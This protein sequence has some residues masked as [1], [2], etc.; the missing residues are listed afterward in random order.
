MLAYDDKIRVIELARTSGIMAASSKYNLSRNRVKRY[1]NL[2]PGLKTGAG[3][4]KTMDPQMEA[5]LLVWIQDYS[6][7][8]HEFPKKELICGQA[9]MLTRVKG[10][11]ASKGWLEKFMRRNQL[12]LNSLRVNQNKPTKPKKVQ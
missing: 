8:Y 9:K 5:K 3:G 10:F 2:G 6:A 11:A 4:R 7:T 1:L 12:I